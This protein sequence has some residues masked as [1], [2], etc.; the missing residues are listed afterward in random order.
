MHPSAGTESQAPVLPDDYAL[1]AAIRSGDAKSLAALYDRYSGVVFSLCLRTLGDHAEAE[2]LLID[3]F[4]ELW[5]RRDR[6][7]PTRG[8]ALAHILGLARSR[9]LDRLRSRRTRQS[10]LPRAMDDNDPER[11]APLSNEQPLADIM[12]SERR[13][14]VATALNSLPADQRKA[15]E[16]AFFDG[17]SHS[18]T[19]E[20]LEEPLGTVKSRIRQ[21]LLRLRE[22]LG[23]D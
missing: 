15:I 10:R 7:D 6:F 14:R 1:M 5:D 17:L 18:E 20:R 4:F 21:G 2:D 23:A 11:Q 3:I 16:L 22:V 9:A 13:E 8:R 19:A 12:L